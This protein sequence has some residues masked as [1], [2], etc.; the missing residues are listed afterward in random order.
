MIMESCG[1]KST[2][3]IKEH[4]DMQVVGEANNGLAAVEKVF[5]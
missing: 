4:P 1:R 5:T 2:L 3:W